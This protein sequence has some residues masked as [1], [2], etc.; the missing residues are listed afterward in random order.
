[1]K[2]TKVSIETN[3]KFNIV[4]TK[5]AVQNA[6][7][8]A[9]L[10]LALREAT[11]VIKTL[12]EK[13]QQ[14]QQEHKKHLTKTEK[15]LSSIK[16]YRKQDKTERKKIAK[17]VVDYWFEKVTTPISSITI[18]AQPSCKWPRKPERFM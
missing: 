7:D 14:T 10:I 18:W 17:D 4:A 12:S 16:E 6:F 13:L 1:M 9:G 8:N 2:M 3:Y 5:D 15:I 11:G